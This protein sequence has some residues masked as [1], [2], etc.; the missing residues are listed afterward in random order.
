LSPLYVGSHVDFSSVWYRYPPV[1]V[2]VPTS[3]M[4]PP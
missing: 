1:E 2:R 3:R 4:L